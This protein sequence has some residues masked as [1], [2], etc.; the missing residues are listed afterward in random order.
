MK[1]EI[2]FENDN[3]I[4]VNKPSGLLSVPDR[5]QSEVSLKDILLDKYGGIFTVHRLDKDTSGVIVFAKNEQTHKH[6]SQQFE[7]RETEKFYVGLVLGRLSVPSGLIDM[8][9]IEHPVKKGV[10][11]TNRKGKA[12]QTAYQVLEEF[13]NYSWMQFQIFT[14]RTHQIRVHMKHLGHAIVCDEVYGD[15]H[16]VLLSAI[17]KKFKLGKDV[18]EEKPLLNR[19]ALHAQKLIIKDEEGNP[20]VLEAAVPKDMRATLNQLEKWN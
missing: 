4:A 9:I 16:P 20:H 17:K 10:M 2:I 13:N 8:P 18:L 12:S 6:L 1:L 5:M 11:T 19:L 14:G 7:Q 3:F 15:G